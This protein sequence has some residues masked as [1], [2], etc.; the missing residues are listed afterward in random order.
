VLRVAFALVALLLARQGTHAAPPAFKV[1]TWNIRSGMGITGFSTRRWSIPGISG[2]SSPRWS[3]NTLNCTDASKPMNAWGVG[4]PQK[5]LERLRGDE[6][7]VA[8]ALQEAW[9]CAKPEQVNSVLRFKAASRE[10][11]G[12]ALIA[13]HGFDGAP[14]L[15]RIGAGYE[16]WIVG[17][18]VCLDAACSVALPMFSTHW[19]GSDEQWPKQARNVVAFL[20]KQRTP[21]LFMGDLNVFKIDQWNPRVPC[22]NDDKP[23]RSAAIAILDKAGYADAWKATQTGPGWT[24]MASRR[25]C[26]SPEGTLYKRIDYVQ[27]KGLRVLGTALFAR[28]APGA[29]APSDHAGLIAELAISSAST[30]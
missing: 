24:G 28:V 12:V 3:H 14:V 9:N 10:Q 5:E 16:S 19:G 18:T 8:I 11:N 25:G 2:L 17:G 29:D 26:G 23:G 4:L 22:T 21:H 20:E 7:I 27:T 30:R 6:R 15:H 13:R 1:A